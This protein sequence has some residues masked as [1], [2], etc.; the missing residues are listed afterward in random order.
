MATNPFYKYYDHSN[1]LAGNNLASHVLEVFSIGTGYSV[2]FKAFIDSFNDKYTSEWNNESV[3]GRMDGIATFK[4]TKRSISL[5]IGVPAGDIKEAKDNL[6]R[7]SDLINFLYPNYQVVG[8]AANMVSAP[9]LKMKL[10]NLIVDVTKEVN[11]YSALASGLVG[12]ISGITYA[13]EVEYGMYVEDGNLYPKSLKV[14]FEFTV[15]HTHPLGFNTSS[16]SPLGLRTGGFPYKSGNIP[17]VKAELP[18]TPAVES[19]HTSASEET[20][21][22]GGE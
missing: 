2:Q 11:T 15:I 5:T 12:Y 1:T 14:A 10:A 16:K 22:S 20:L 17:T 8:T 4:S 18:S 9:L 21:I 6:A 13:P 7:I 19:D 3:F